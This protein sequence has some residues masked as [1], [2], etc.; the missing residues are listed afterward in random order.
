MTYCNYIANKLLI[1]KCDVNHIYIL[2]ELIYVYKV[3]LV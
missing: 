2:I 1:Y 3:N